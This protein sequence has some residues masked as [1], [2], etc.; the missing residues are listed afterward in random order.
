MA[1]IFI[2]PLQMIGASFSGI[3]KAMDMTS[4]FGS[5]V[6]GCMPDGVIWSFAS[7]SPSIF[8]MLGPWMSTSRSPTW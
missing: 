5:A 3:R 4:R 7:S 1:A 2:G 6:I 8:G